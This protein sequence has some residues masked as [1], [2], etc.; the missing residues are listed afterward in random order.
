MSPG[1]GYNG[2]GNKTFIYTGSSVTPFSK[3]KQVYGN[4]LERINT[5]KKTGNLS[6][7]KITLKQKTEIRKKIKKE[8]RK[9]RIKELILFVLSGFILL[10]VIYYLLVWFVL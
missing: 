6:F 10:I 9:T 8:L 3:I 7:E 2:F 4:E 1:I 5:D